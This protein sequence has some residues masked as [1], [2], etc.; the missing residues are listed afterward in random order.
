MPDQEFQQVIELTQRLNEQSVAEAE[1]ELGRSRDERVNMFKDLYG[2]IGDLN[3]NWQRDRAGALGRYMADFDQFLRTKTN[4]TADQARTMEESERSRM[5]E[6]MDQVTTHNANLLSSTETMYQREARDQDQ[7]ITA[8]LDAEGN[9][10]EVRR[11]A[12]GQ[13][14]GESVTSSLW[15]G[16]NKLV[17][18]AHSMGAPIA[19]VSI[20]EG[21]RFGIATYEHRLRERKA[22]FKIAAAGGQ[23]TPSGSSFD[24]QGYTEGIRDLRAK[25]PSLREHFNEIGLM[26]KQQMPDLNAKDL[27]ATVNDTRQLAFYTDESMDKL[28]GEMGTL[29]RKLGVPSKEVAGKMLWMTELGRFY[30][31]S[32]SVNIDIGK[33]REEIINL[34]DQ[35]KLYGMSIDDA[36]AMV[37]NFAKELDRGVVSLDDITTATLGYSKTT[38]TKLAWIGEQAMRWMQNQPGYEDLYATL[39]K[40]NY[41]KAVLQRAMRGIS[42]NSKALYKEYGL[43]WKNHEKWARQLGIA[44]ANGVKDFA[45]AMSDSTMQRNWIWRQAAEMAGT[46]PAGTLIGPA[47]K[48]LESATHGPGEAG[49][50]EGAASGVVSRMDGWRSWV[51]KNQDATESVLEQLWEHARMAATNLLDFAEGAAKSMDAMNKALADAENLLQNPNRENLSKVGD[52][53]KT[54][55]N[56]VKDDLFSGPQKTPGA[57]V[58]KLT[59]EWLPGSES[60]DAFEKTWRGTTPQSGGEILPRTLAAGALESHLGGNQPTREGALH[61]YGEKAKD[62]GKGISGAFTKGAV[63]FVESGQA[64]K[65]VMDISVLWDKYFS[66]NAIVND[67]REKQANKSGG[68]GSP[69]GANP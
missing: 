52:D 43:D 40:L 51:D 29:A 22:E 46:L 35:N 21:L 69:G 26:L 62:V 66:S 2:S 20:E 33:F 13:K 50:A 53:V 7:T 4:L 65:L 67:M 68:M 37:Y 55:Y 14:E 3:R 10:K 39:Q 34:T 61:E 12:E 38:P 54:I 32:H 64:G 44:A 42:S 19:G 60:P 8:I 63:D 9:I 45:T 16:L 57:A 27:V 31:R 56:D 17:S 48:L 59:S 1:R 36:G 15:E 28:A 30:V 18:I 47:Q 6:L 23:L 58:D 5:T 24:M 49:T 11:E 41:N 25:F